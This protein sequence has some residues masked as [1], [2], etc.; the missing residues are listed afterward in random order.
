MHWGGIAPGL[1]A[2]IEGYGASEEAHKEVELGEGQGRRSYDLA[3]STLRDRGGHITGRLL[4]LR[5]T[6]SRKR[7]E[8]ALKESEERY[9]AVVE[10]AAEG[11]FLLDAETTRILDSNA[12]FQ[13]LLGYGAEELLGMTL[14]D[15]VA[16]D[17]HSV[18]ANVR[19][20]LAEKR[21]FVGERRYRRKDGTLVDFEVS[22]GRVFYGGKE[23]VCAVVRDITERKRTDA[24]LREA[25]LK[26][27]TLVEQ[28]PAI[29]Y[30]EDIETQ[31]TLYD[32]PQIETIL[33]YPA[34]TYQKDPHYWDRILHPDDRERV[35][36]A[37]AEATGRGQ[38]KLEYRCIAGDGRVVWLR[39]EAMIVR[40]E[41]GNPRFW[42]GVIFDI[43]ERKRTEGELIR[44]RTE[45]ARSNA[46]I[47]HFAYLIAHDLRAPL[48]GI[49]G[50][51]HILLE[52]YA[53]S[54][55]EV[56]K[57]HLRRV[58]DGALR[59]GRLIDELLELSRLSRTEMRRET[60]NLS[61]LA[62]A[63]AEELA[64]PERRVELVIADG[65]TASGDARL[66]RV[67]LWNL[68]DNAWK[69]TENEP[70]AR[71]EFG[72][73][74][75]WEE[76]VY[77]VRDN[78]VGFDMAYADK[79]FGVFQR[80][81]GPEEFGGTGM[82]LATV[83]RIVERHGGRVWAEGAVGRGATFFFTLRPERPTPVEPA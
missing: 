4:M 80:L 24:M 12:A 20:V 64:R 47:E 32:S 54:L 35:R 77:F 9:R 14:Y 78:G 39:D 10:Q 23:V 6:T 46:E 13:R 57:H 31:A 41:E 30:I 45:L 36:A 67:A 29:I 26:Y 37:E 22:A 33:G 42:Q 15:L 3:L 5:D 50:F 83:Q 72:A 49:N 1:D 55:D 38:F 28:I 81:H 48:R 62:R 60:V 40:D 68:L 69:F 66:L 7:D 16:H 76:L 52:D 82:G 44:Q 59:M 73:T 70:N 8:E 51:S 18:E 61:A 63:F 75:R 71:I 27:R 19:R 58:R 74:Q 21:S 79:L 65:L 17:R 11:I 43:T 2:L 53:D 34:D 25:E 56:G